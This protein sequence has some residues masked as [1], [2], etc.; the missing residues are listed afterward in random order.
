MLN[1]NKRVALVTGSGRGM[2]KAIA[3]K[4]AQEHITVVINDLDKDLAETTQELIR[5]SGGIC[6]LSIGDASDED[7]VNDMVEHSISEY[8]SIDI[9]VNNARVLRP[10][11]LVDI[12]LAECEFVI[13][14][15]LTS[16]FYALK[17]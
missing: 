8:G 10:T 12:P 1:T 16:T 3:L 2:G 4:L 17:K 9:L 5:H 7:F 14:V 6:S 11:P 13:K 15:N